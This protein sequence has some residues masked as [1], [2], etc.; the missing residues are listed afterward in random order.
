[1]APATEE[2]RP[3]LMQPQQHQH[4]QKS[5]SASLFNSTSPP[6]SATTSTTNIPKINN[7]TSTKVAQSNLPPPLAHRP[8]SE[9]PPSSTPAT[10]SVIPPYWR[11]YRNA[12][13]A[14]QTSLDAAT[15]SGSG[16]R[17]SLIR[18]E[19]HTEDPA[20]E[21][22]KG[23]WARSVTIDDY[24][25]VKGR[26]G[27]GAYVVWIVRI[28]TLE[29]PEVVVRMRYS[30]FDDLRHRLVAA[31]PYAKSALPQLPPKSAI[32]KFSHKFLET[33]RVGLAYFLNCVLLNP[34]FSGSAVLKD[35]LFNH[36]G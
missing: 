20:N 19:D 21:G 28:Q 6:P 3:P 13:Q 18:L 23:L 2:A 14:S 1:M 30:E 5:I 16:P 8:E 12:S 10:T 15:V 26:S 35:V 32:F 29:G 36:V 4:R 24:T 17:R 34:E 22:S 31:F 9:P 7:S 11:H 27:I 25:V 33:R